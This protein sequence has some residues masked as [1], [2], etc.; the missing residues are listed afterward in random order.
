[1]LFKI[2]EKKA[3]IKMAI[4]K[5]AV[6]L[7][8]VVDENMRDEIKL[9]A[10]EKGMS[11]TEWEN[12]AFE[13]AIEEAH[14]RYSLANFS[15]ERLNQLTHSVEECGNRVDN[16]SDLLVDLIHMINNLVSGDSYLNDNDQDGEETI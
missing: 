6:R 10:K 2:L 14:G 5:G 8:V 1:M 15:A 16:M 7:S 3:G 9:L 4:R 13:N 12:M 11:M